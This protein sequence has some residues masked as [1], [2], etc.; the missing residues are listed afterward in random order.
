MTPRARGDR[1]ERVRA[2]RVGD[3]DLLP[4]PTIPLVVEERPEPI[5]ITGLEPL[6]EFAAPVTGDLGFE[7]MPLDDDL[8]PTSMTRCW[9][10]RVTTRS[11]LPS[12]RSSTN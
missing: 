1:P 6:P 12:S 10:G 7:P 4:D 9:P 5:T 2:D 3:R 11:S 8:L